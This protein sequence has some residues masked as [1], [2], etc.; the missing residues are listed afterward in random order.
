MNPITGKFDTSVENAVDSVL[1]ILIYRGIYFG[2]FLNTFGAVVPI[3]EMREQWKMYP[4]KD[5]FF[6]QELFP[7]CVFEEPETES[8][9][10][11]A[12]S[13]M[14]LQRHDRDFDSDFRFSKSVA[15]IFK[16]EEN[17]FTY[18]Y[19]LQS[20][21]YK[22]FGI[23]LRMSEESIGKN[24]VEPV[25]QMAKGLGWTHAILISRGDLTPMARRD[26]TMQLYKFPCEFFLVKQTQKNKL[27][28]DLVP[29]YRVLNEKGIRIICEKYKCTPDKF[30]KMIETDTVTRL[31]NL[32]KGCVVIEWP[33]VGSMYAPWTFRCVQAMER[34]DDGIVVRG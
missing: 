34:S 14:F 21:M 32:P 20:S 11:E 27:R 22:K 8:T 1:D 30:P 15:G 16:G 3:D 29:W 23:L 19:H 33:F 2:K 28:H 4:D 10:H 13:R 17:V 24:D 25:V 18:P 5:K 7:L 31:L 6:E 12:I 9:D 26:L